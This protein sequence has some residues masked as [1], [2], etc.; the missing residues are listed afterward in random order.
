MPGAGSTMGTGPCTGQSNPVM[1]RDSQLKTR[2][3]SSHSLGRRDSQNKSSSSTHRSKRCPAR[4][5]CRQVQTDAVCIGTQTSRLVL[6]IGQRIML[7]QR[8]GLRALGVDELTHPNVHGG[9]SICWQCAPQPR[10]WQIGG[11]LRDRPRFVVMA[12]WCTRGR[13]RDSRDSP[14]AQG[15]GGRDSP[16]GLRSFRFRTGRYCDAAD[17]RHVDALPSKVHMSTTST[18]PVYVTLR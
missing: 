10:S 3:Y 17:T 4:C 11:C 16:V 14:A 18:R 2:R 6:Q 13:E 7:V 15:E 9:V 12:W 5:G 8:G 1:R